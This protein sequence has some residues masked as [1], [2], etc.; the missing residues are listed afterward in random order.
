M[1]GASSFGLKY[2][3]AKGTAGLVAAKGIGVAGLGFAALD[4]GG[5][6]ISGTSGFKEFNTEK[7]ASTTGKKIG[8]YSAFT[9]GAASGSSAYNYFEFSN[10]CPKYKCCTVQNCD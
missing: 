8:Q 9:L 1:G 10:C 3:A 5:N 2:I 4:L 6:L 7:L